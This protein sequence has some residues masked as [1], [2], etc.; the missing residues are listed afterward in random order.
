MEELSPLSPAPSEIVIGI[1][2]LLA[3]I[4]VFV[5]SYRRNRYLF[6]RSVLES[7]VVALVSAIFW[8]LWIIGSVASWRAI[9]ARWA[10]HRRARRSLV[11]AA[12]RSA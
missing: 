10:D 6:D 9:S 8:P 11:P 7:I 12:D 5:A 4:L 3:P 1:V 2:A